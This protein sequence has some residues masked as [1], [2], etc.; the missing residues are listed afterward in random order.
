MPLVSVLEVGVSRKRKTN[1]F[2]VLVCGSSESRFPGLPK[3]TSN[4]ARAL[5]HKCLVL[6]NPDFQDY[7]KNSSIFVRAVLTRNSHSGGSGEC[8]YPGLLGTIF[9][10]SHAQF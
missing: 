3:S 5:F 8:A 9:R 7:R 4:F 10:S 1:N 2:N 6:V